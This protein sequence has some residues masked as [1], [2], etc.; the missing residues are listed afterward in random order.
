MA[1]SKFILNLASERIEILFGL[2]VAAQKKGGKKLSKRYIKIAW[3]M[4]K[5]YKMGIPNRIKRMVCKKC[6]E[7][8]IPGLNSRVIVASSKNCIIYKCKCGAENKM[9]YKKPT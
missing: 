1:K 6:G 8:Q 9:F 3:D 2:A 7:V 5:H 4:S